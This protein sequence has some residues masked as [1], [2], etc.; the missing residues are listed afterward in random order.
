MLPE[1]ADVRAHYDA[2]IAEDNDP[3]RDPP[4]LQEYMDLWDGQPFVDAME[5]S[6]NC[7]VLEIGVGTGRLAA[8]TAPL[9]R[10]FTGIDISPD[11]IARAAENLQHFK[12]V[13]LICNDFLTHPFTEKYDVIYSSL[14][15]MHFSDKQAFVS[16]AAELLNTG[17]KFCLSIDK[18]TD[19]YIDMQTR[20]IRIFPDFPQETE[21]FIRRA[22]LTVARSFERDFAFIFICTR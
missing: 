12:N 7:S 13:Q 10:N 15:M 3:F 22:G 20:R 9:C 2:L 1:T 18:N 6:K 4:V 11:T 17:G 14:T 19:E 8:R 21:I 5:L 16:R